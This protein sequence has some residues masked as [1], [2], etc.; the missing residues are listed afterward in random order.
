MK[1]ILILTAAML[2]VLSGVHAQRFVIQIEGGPSFPLGAF[3]ADEGSDAGYARMGWTGAVSIGYAF[4]DNV[5][6]GVKAA[7]LAHG[8]KEGAVPFV[9][10]SPWNTTAI[11]GAIVL[12]SPLSDAIF[13]EGNAGA[14]L[15]FTQFPAA[16]LSIG[17][18]QVNRAAET[19]QGLGYEVGAGMRYMLSRDFALRLGV[20][21]LGGKPS[22]EQ[23]GTTFEQ[24][25]GAAS[26]NWGIV[27]ML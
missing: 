8:V 12:S 25:I 14:G 26:V 17:G 5:R 4:T 6:G 23:N 22:F 13:V 21:Y 3:G 24:K 16:S 15:L 10:V 2:F 9:E 27:F 20:N 11:L 1:N 18:V 7:F 19:G